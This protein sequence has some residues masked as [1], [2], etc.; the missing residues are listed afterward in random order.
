MKMK[1]TGKGSKVKADVTVKE[2]QSF[3][4]FNNRVGAVILLAVLVLAGLYLATNGSLGVSFGNTDENDAASVADT[5][6][7]AL[8]VSVIDDQLTVS[9]QEPPKINGW[10]VVSDDSACKQRTAENF[11]DTDKVLDSSE[12]SASATITFEEDTDYCFWPQ[13]DADDV[14][15]LFLYISSELIEIKSLGDPDDVVITYHLVSV[16]DD[17]VTVAIKPAE[18][19]PS[20]LLGWRVI[21]ASDEKACKVSAFE[22]AKKVLDNSKNSATATIPFDE[23]TGYCFWARRKTDILKVE[24]YYVP[25]DVIKAEAL[26]S[27]GGIKANYDEVIVQ[28]DQMT[29][30]IG[31]PPAVNGWKVI[32]ISNQEECKHKSDFDTSAVVLDHSDSSANVTITFEGDISYCFWPKRETDTIK[33]IFFYVAVKGSPSSSPDAADGP[34]IITGVSSETPSLPTTPAPV[35]PPVNT[36]VPSTKD[37]AITQIMQITQETGTIL[38]V[39]ATRDISA[40]SAIRTDYIEGSQ[41]DQSAFTNT[42]SNK[43]VD[44]EVGSSSIPLTDDDNGKS[45]CFR[46]EENRNG[47]TY[48]AFKTSNAVRL[49]SDSGSDEEEPKENKQDEEDKKDK[50]SSDNKDTDKKDTGEDAAADAGESDAGGIGAQILFAVIVLTIVAGV[51]I[52]IVI[53]VNLS[54]NNKPKF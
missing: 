42:D 38:K 31:E 4:S 36:P 33:V 54:R 46:I 35:T 23:D 53:V 18:S 14:E 20:E 13:R 37:F 22:N 17:Q 8:E 10:K 9:Y 50:T 2:K 25:A 26:I 51:V 52:V 24:L 39:V 30:S 19:Q 15:A 41:C 3:L 7:N 27:S 16:Q 48:Y 12:A 6:N 34:Q 47:Q 49:A 45:F 1:T 44:V 40:G 28:G 43:R 29:V 32:R 11:L 5:S 21:K